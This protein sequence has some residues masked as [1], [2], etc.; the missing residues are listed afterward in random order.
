MTRP[1]KDLKGNFDVKLSGPGSE[2]TG[3]EGF[4]CFNQVCSTLKKTSN[5]PLAALSADVS[6]LSRVYDKM[7]SQLFFALEGLHADSADERSVRI[8]ALLVS[9]QV[10]FPL[11]SSSTDVAEEPSTVTNN[12]FFRTTRNVFK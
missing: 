9:S 1:L 4:H 3:L 12:N 2:V 5:I 11:Q 10:V 8:V 7:Q 6:L